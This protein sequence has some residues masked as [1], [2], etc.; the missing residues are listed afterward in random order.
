MKV[1]KKLNYAIIYGLIFGLLDT[2]LMLPL[3]FENKSI[4]ILGAFLQRF[5]IGFLIPFTDL[6]LSNTLNGILTS[7]LISVPTAII[8]GSYIPII[9]TG[10]IGG[11]IIGWHSGKTKYGK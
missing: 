7:L 5:A 8:T 3:E 1:N 10:I 9:T 4:A 11:A 6:P 2:S